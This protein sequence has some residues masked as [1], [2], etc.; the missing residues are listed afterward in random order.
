MTTRQARRI[1]KSLLS[2]TTLVLIRIRKSSL[3]C[4]AFSPLRSSGIPPPPA[5][6]GQFAAEEPNFLLV[7]GPIVALW[8]KSCIF[9]KLS[10]FSW[11]HL[12]VSGATGLSQKVKRATKSS[13]LSAFF[14]S[15]TKPIGRCPGAGIMATVCMPAKCKHTVLRGRKG[16]WPSVLL[17]IF[18]QPLS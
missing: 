11:V 13:A 8:G 5:L 12:G 10:G 2:F 17:R 4:I 6:T 7:M 15:H 18:N 1:W 14:L 3:K 9:T 16:E